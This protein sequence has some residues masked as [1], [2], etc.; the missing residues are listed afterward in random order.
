MR[1]LLA[2]MIVSFEQGLVPVF[3]S[4]TLLTLL[5]L[6]VAILSF[7]SIVFISFLAEKIQAQKQ[8]K[9]GAK[10][11]LSLLAVFLGVAGVLFA[12]FEPG[13][14]LLSLALLLFFAAFLAEKKKL[15]IWLMFS[16]AVAFF[17]GWFFM[18]PLI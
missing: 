17:I 8:L 2:Q 12:A 9:Q 15:A 10:N 11:L 13:S 1:N 16:L 5:Y 14:Q 4:P 3:A 6:R 7:A 18:F